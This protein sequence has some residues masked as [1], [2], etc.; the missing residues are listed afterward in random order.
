LCAVV[1]IATNMHDANAIEQFHRIAYSILYI[2]DLVKD[3][4]DILDKFVNKFIKES[5]K[6]LY[7]CHC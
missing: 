6:S 2:A 3:I 7:V 5:I 4:S 1:D